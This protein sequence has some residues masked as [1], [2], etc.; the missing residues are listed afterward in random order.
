MA[1]QR[2]MLRS[3]PA[4][5]YGE[6]EVRQ[7]TDDLS[8]TRRVLGSP[9]GMVVYIAQLR[10]GSVAVRQTPLHRLA[11]GWVAGRCTQPGLTG[12]LNAGGPSGAGIRGGLPSHS[13]EAGG[14][15][16]EEGGG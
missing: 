10:A 9:Y 2:A 16:A 6:A 8:F 13:R 15:S 5:L 3:S 4:P 7:A 14:P 11:G 12:P 1:I